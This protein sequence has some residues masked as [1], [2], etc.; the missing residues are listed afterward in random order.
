VNKNI[1]QIRQ[2]IF[3]KFSIKEKNLDKEKTSSID[4]TVILVLLTAT[5]SLLDIYSHPH[6]GIADMKRRKAIVNTIG[7]I[8]NSLGNFGFSAALAISAVFVKNIFQEAFHSKIMQNVARHGF[9]AFT[10]SIL[11]LNALIE[12][13]TQTRE[14]LPDFVMGALGVALGIS[15]TKGVLEKW[16]SAKKEKEASIEIC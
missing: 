3:S 12:T 14:A 7:P 15:A 4:A 1:E 8:A 10:A 11:T 9:L 13:T 16:K 6:Q 2:T 5:I